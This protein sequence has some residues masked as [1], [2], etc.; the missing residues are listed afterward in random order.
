MDLMVNCIRKWALRLD[1][2]IAI[3]GLSPNWALKKSRPIV[4]KKAIIWVGV[5][6]F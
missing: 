2:V 1:I 4:E 6:A 5:F 3:R